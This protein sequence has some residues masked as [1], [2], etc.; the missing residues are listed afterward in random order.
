MLESRL[1]TSI[2]R[3][4]GEGDGLRWPGSFSWL[5]DV[6]WLSH[7]AILFLSTGYTCSSPSHEVKRGVDALGLETQKS[8][9]RIVLSRDLIDYRSIPGLVISYDGSFMFLRYR[10]P[11][12]LVEKG[13][14]IERSVSL[15][16]NI[17]C[18]SVEQQW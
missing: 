9:E 6:P 10:I 17:C 5:T 14:L 2:L 8:G 7:E 15:E 13:M 4:S 12:P 16:R 3:A 11:L 1:T 18:E